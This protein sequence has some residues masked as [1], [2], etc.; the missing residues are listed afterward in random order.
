MAIPA[1][2]HNLR[3]INSANTLLKHYSYPRESGDK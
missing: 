1:N 3:A 2:K